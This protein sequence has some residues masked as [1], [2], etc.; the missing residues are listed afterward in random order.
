MGRPTGQFTPSGMNSALLP[1]CVASDEHENSRRKFSIVTLPPQSRA[2]RL[3]A[4]KASPSKSSM[5]SCMA[6]LATVIFSVLSGRSS[7]DRN[8]STPPSLCCTQVMRLATPA[9]SFGRPRGFLVATSRRYSK[10]LRVMRPSP[11]ESRPRKSKSASPSKPKFRTPRRKSSI[12]S[13]YWWD[14]SINSHVF[15]MSKPVDSHSNPAK[16]SRFS[17][18][19]PPSSKNSK[20]RGSSLGL[21]EFQMLRA[22]VAR[23]RSWRHARV[24]STKATRPERRMSI[25]SRQARSKE[26]RCCTSTFTNWLTAEFVWA[27]A[28]EALNALKLASYFT[29]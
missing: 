17:V 5:T 4:C 16:V 23:P 14:V 18:S 29:I 13:Q 21:K 22:C 9:L 25:S 27:A 28:S 3:A 2:A 11:S 10:S 26:P 6:R 19:S 7:L 8:S 24:K 20:G 1:P 12:E 15:A